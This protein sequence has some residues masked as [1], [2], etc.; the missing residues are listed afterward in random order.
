M[1]R[2][3]PVNFEIVE[4]KI[5]HTHASIHLITQIILCLIRLYLMCKLHPITSTAVFF[6]SSFLVLYWS[7]IFQKLT[8]LF[9][10]EGIQL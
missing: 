2:H 1:L 8:A 3:L 6:A 7:T 10:T 9:S 4:R 5:P